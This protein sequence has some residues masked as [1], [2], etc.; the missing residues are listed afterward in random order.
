MFNDDS[1]DDEDNGGSIED[2]LHD[3]ENIKKGQ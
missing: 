1:W 2:L 3:Y